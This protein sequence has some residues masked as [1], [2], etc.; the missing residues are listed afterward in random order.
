MKWELAQSLLVYGRV[1]Q[2]KGDAERAREILTRAKQMF[3]E[4]G[5]AWGTDRVERV[6]REI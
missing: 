4:M 3:E 6:L 5:V 1:L 2:A